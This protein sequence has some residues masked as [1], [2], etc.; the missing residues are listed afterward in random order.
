MLLQ[1]LH[2]LKPVLTSNTMRN[3]RLSLNDLKVFLKWETIVSIILALLSWYFVLTKFN[4]GIMDNYAPL[5]SG[6]RSSNTGGKVDLAEIFL[7]SFLYYKGVIFF[8]NRA[9][10]K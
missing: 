5:F 6:V 8:V 3:N 1:N 7:L 2:T 4:S 9:T 10:K